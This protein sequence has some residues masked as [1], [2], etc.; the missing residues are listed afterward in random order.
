M[1]LHLDSVA[2]G[3]P[4]TS[5]AGQTAGAGLSGSSRAGSR[6]SNPA[7]FPDSVSISDTGSVIARNAAD[8]A[9]RIEQLTASVR[10]GS[11]QVSSSVLSSAIVAQATS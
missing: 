5:G 1:R 10:A 3:S 2:G 6:Q 8:R 9:S 4:E 11:Y 7:A